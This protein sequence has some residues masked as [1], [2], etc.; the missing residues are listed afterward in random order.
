M[1]TTKV[2]RN[3][4]NKNTVTNKQND[5]KRLI[6]RSDMVKERISELQ[7]SQQIL[8]NTNYSNCYIKRR[9]KDTKERIQK[10]WDSIKQSNLN[11]TGIPEEKEGEN[12]AE[13]ISE[14]IMTESFPTIMKGIKTQIQH[15]QAG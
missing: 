5:L 6:I 7:D 9:M 8:P 15:T 14:E 4:K 12:K 10:L 1:E 3:V 2:K 11:V 13:E